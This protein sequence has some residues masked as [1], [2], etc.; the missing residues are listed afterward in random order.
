MKVPLKLSPGITMGVVSGRC[1]VP[2][3]SAVRK[4]NWGL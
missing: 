3:T 1:T 4:K 2:V